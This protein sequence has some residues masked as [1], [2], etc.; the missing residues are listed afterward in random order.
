M[1]KTLF[2]ALATSSLLL[3]NTVAQQ[4]APSPELP[5]LPSLN[6]LT[7]LPD[8]GIVPAA[9]TVPTPTPSP[10]PASAPPTREQIQAAEADRNWA[11]EAVKAKQEEAA[12]R[13]AEA[14]ATVPP[15]PGLEQ[16]PLATAL[17][18][19][20]DLREQ[21]PSPTA[22]PGQLGTFQPA[23]GGVGSEQTTTTATTQPTAQPAANPLTSTPSAP[24]RPIVGPPPTPEMTLPTHGRSQPPGPNIVKLS[25]DPNF[26]PEGYVDPLGRLEQEQAA[27]AATRPNPNSRPETVRPTYR[28]IRQRIPNPSDPP[29]F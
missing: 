5:D 10:L 20:A 13:A 22:R 6:P 4:Q 3:I 9:P 11:V 23:I 21:T 28:D 29:R 27:A 14:S 8:S 24:V 15:V 19:L 16:D 26:I 17:D 2:L 18:P 1:A 7:P 25:S 12:A